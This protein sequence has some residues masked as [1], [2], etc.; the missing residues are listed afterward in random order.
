MLVMPGAGCR[1]VCPVACRCLGLPIVEI[2]I[3][4]DTRMVT[5][6]RLT[7]EFGYFLPIIGIWAM[8]AIEKIPT[9]LKAGYKCTYISHAD[10]VISCP[11]AECR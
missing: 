8:E 10:L 6:D 11:M 2:V 5:H 3:D 4:I 9:C 7:Y 1:A